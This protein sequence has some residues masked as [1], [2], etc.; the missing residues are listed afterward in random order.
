[1][2][3]FSRLAIVCFCATV[4][5]SLAS[6]DFSRANIVRPAP[7]F[8]WVGAGGKPENFREFR[9]QPVVLL[10]AP[11]PRSW[12]FRRQVGHLQR[13]YQRLAATGAVCVAAFTQ[14]PGIIRSNIPFALAQ[15]GA[16]VAGLIGAGSG[17]NIAVIGKDGNVDVL[18]DRVLSG[19]RVLDIINNSFAVQQSLRR[20]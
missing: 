6:A 5:L 1:V 15:D 17:F 3:N 11:D 2:F 19:Q 8:A 9:G 4:L 13:V 12:T 20:N 7:D 14:T 10:I 18:T 16:Q